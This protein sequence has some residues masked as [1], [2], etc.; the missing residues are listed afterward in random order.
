MNSKEFKDHFS[1]EAKKGGFEKAFGGWIKDNKETIVVLDLQKS[2]YGDYYQLNIKIFIQGFWNTTYVKNKDLVKKEVGDIIGG[3]PKES[4][5]IFHLD[6]LLTD[7]ERISK[8]HYLFSCYIIPF[9]NN[10][11]TKSGI[12]ELANREELHLTPA[13]KDEL[14]K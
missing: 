5:P 7:E 2:N 10:A 12:K 14:Y 3:E 4:S 8:L 13:I 1:E 11:S 9:T 6:N